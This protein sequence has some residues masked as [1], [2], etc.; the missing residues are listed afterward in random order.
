MGK[1]LP[2]SRHDP[3]RRR[4]H[5]P[6]RHHLRD[7]RR[8]LSPQNRPRT[9]LRPRTTSSA[10][11]N[12]RE[13]QIVAPRQSNRR[14]PLANDSLTQITFQYQDIS[15]P[16][17]R[18]SHPD[19]RATGARALLPHLPQATALIADRGYDSNWFRNSL[20]ERGTTPVSRLPKTARRRWNITKRSTASATRSRTCSPSSRTGDASPHAMTAAPIPSSRPSASQPQSPSI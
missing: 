2:R 13:Q 8:K 16:D 7:E 19:C 14:S 1:N 12:H 17:C 15:H 5:R 3:R 11:D 4:S 10:R 18:A 6:S 20:A 9:P